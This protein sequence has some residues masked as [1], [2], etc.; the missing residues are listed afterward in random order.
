MHRPTLVTCV[1]L[2]LAAT[3]SACGSPAQNAAPAPGSS[4]GPASGAASAPAKV[5]PTPTPTPMAGG[6]KPGTNHSEAA[7]AYAH[8]AQDVHNWLT[9]GKT[10]P[11]YPDH[12][13]AFLTFDDGPNTTITPKDLDVLKAQGVHATFYYV[14]KQLG[15]KTK[16]VAERTIA[17]GHAV[18]V[19]SH[20]H[21]YNYLYPGRSGSAEHVLADYDKATQEMKSI[22]GPE[23]VNHGFRYPGGHMSWKGL[24]AADKGLAAKGVYWIDWNTM[25][26]DAEPPK[27]RAKTADQ[28]VAA[29][30]AGIREDS[31][32][33]PNVA[34]VLMHDAEDKSLTTQALPAVIADLKAKGYEFGVID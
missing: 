16:A 19:H 1:S 34:V 20:S 7:S 21:D 14:T 26:A 4:A 33:N 8:S 25:T 32:K 30:N 15:P 3:L 10:T 24:D 11:N 12:K 2:A 29:V 5:T 22:F 23:F 31:A 28:M 13:I 18:D 6:V 27:T 17:E 9:Q